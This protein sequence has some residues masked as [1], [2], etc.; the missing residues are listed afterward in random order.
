M[1]I[2]MKLGWGW[3]LPQA[4]DEEPPDAAASIANAPAPKRPDVPVQI[5]RFRYLEDC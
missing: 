2:D 1:R 5:G 3:L 4:P